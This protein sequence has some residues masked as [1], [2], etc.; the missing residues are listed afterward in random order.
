MGGAAKGH[1]PRDRSDGAAAGD[2]GGDDSAKQPAR[3]DF[4]VLARFPAA[5]ATGY[6]APAAGLPY[7]SA[8]L[9]ATLHTGRWHQ[10]RRHLAHAGHHVLGDAKHGKLRWN[11]PAREALRLH[12]LFLHSAELQ[13]DTSAAAALLPP[14]DAALLRACLCASPLAVR[15]PLPPEL[16]SAAAALP[17]WDADVLGDLGAREL[18]QHAAF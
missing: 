8:L 5:A 1:T 17:G 12:R 15:A 2:R 14:D 13:L 6:V 11:G 10:I 16:A 9:A 7:A 3:T 18:Q 4:R